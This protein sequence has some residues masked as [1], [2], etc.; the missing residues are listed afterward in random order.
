MN[1]FNLAFAVYFM[2]LHF[3]APAGA[4]C[5]DKD[6]GVKFDFHFGDSDPTIEP[7]NRR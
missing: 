4:V 1:K 3:L 7:K 5:S 6:L 2:S